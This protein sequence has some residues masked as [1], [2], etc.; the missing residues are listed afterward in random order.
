MNSFIEYISIFLA[1]VG[2]F[3]FIDSLMSH[4]A[5]NKISEFVFGFHDVTF[6]SFE[7]A[8]VEALVGSF[9]KDGRIRYWRTLIVSVLASASI[10]WMFYLNEAWSDS[11]NQ[12]RSFLYGILFLSFTS[13]FV[14]LINLQASYYVYFY[15]KKIRSYLLKFVVDFFLSMS[16]IVI[17]GSA[18]FAMIVIGT[19]LLNGGSAESFYENS[20][21]F[22]ILFMGSFFSVLTASSIFFIVRLLILAIGILVRSLIFVTKLNS[23]A[24]LYTSAHEHPLTFIASIFALP[25]ILYAG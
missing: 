6:R 4:K 21:I 13:F 20:T 19:A 12:E 15:Q 11:E 2:P 10:S 17:S 23:Y 5:K 22:V 24:V 18:F 3:S 25:Y 7:S 16:L 1:I 14:D 8:S 9:F